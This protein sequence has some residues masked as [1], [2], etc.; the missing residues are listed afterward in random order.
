M[1]NT[2]LDKN[3]KS[4]CNGCGICSLMC[5]VNAIKMVEDNE[6]FFYPQIDQS[7][8]IHC[9]KC[10]RVCSNVNNGVNL[11]LA[12]M[13]RL[14]D[15]EELKK[16]TSGGMFYALAKYVIDN[17]GE[18]FGAEYDKN[19]HV[20][21]NHYSKL[22]DLVKLRGTKYVRSNVF[23]SYNEVKT[24]L[25]DG[26]LVLFSGTPCQC[27]ALKLFLEKEY[28]NLITCD[29]ICHSNPSQKIFSSFIEAIEKKYNSKVIKY[30]D[31]PKQLGW[32]WKNSI[33][34][35]QNNKVIKNGVYTRAFLSGIMSRPSCYYCKFADG[36]RVT[37]FTIGDMWGIEHINKEYNDN[38]GLSLLFINSDKAKLIFNKIK[39][40][41]ECKKIDKNEALKYNH[42]KSISVNKNREKFFSNFD[43][44][45]V[46][47]KLKKYSNQFL[48]LKV[49]L[50]LKSKLKKT[51]KI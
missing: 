4:S 3:E 2:Y 43:N 37:D 47:Y 25:N 35:L 26:R 14:T 1:K 33:I 5:P 11:N 48:I 39:P 46:I 22:S 42:H 40:S 7:K 20:R 44:K 32:R 18:V 10:R 8:C 34:V 13:A 49:F 24:I 12:Y 15:K 17:K 29:I 19:M 27:N 28:D 50:R 23:D 36:N 31:R 30:Y 41:L 45:K 38:L 21:H 51:N 6:G 9:N 16:S